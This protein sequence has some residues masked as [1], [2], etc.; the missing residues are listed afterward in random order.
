MEIT[1]SKENGNRKAIISLVFVLALWEELF[2]VFFPVCCNHL[3]AMG[4]QS[5]SGLA[6]LEGLPVGFALCWSELSRRKKGKVIWKEWQATLLRE[7]SGISPL[8]HSVD[9]CF[10]VRSAGPHLLGTACSHVSLSDIANHFQKTN[11]L[12]NIFGSREIVKTPEF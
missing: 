1:F 8:P 9:K 6:V 12:N 5:M 11:V 2:I 4:W 3:R 10:G 7:L